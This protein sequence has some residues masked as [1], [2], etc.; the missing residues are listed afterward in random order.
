MWLTVGVVIASFIA[1][2]IGLRVV[3][4]YRK[5]ERRPYE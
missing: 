2:Y 4:Y 5:D 1:I 3:V